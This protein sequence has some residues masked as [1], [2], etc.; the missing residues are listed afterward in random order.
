MKTLSLT[1]LIIGVLAATLG[2]GVVLVF[3]FHW[4]WLLLPLVWIVS[5]NCFSRKK[6]IASIVLS[7]VVIIPAAAL[8]CAATG[9]DAFGPYI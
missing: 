6:F 3:H 2:T 4:S 8:V 5:L 9:T 7:L 1:F